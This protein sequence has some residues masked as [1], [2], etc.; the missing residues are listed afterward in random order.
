MQKI[1]DEASECHRVSQ[2]ESGWN[3][4]VHTP[5]LDTV[6]GR[7]LRAASLSGFIRACRPLSSRNTFPRKPLETWWI[8]SFMST[9][10]NDPGS[11]DKAG[12]YREV[13]ASL[14]RRLPAFMLNHTDSPG[15]DPGRPGSSNCS[16][17][18]GQ[19]TRGRRGRYRIADS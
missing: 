3:N 13:I 11:Q 7:G 15:Q 6:V 17:H 14:R 1:A 12:Q 4:L 19:A 8:T 2:A 5:L 9:P 18:R 10:P 16:Q